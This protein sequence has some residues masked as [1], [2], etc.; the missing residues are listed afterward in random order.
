MILILQIIKP[1]TLRLSEEITSLFEPTQKHPVKYVK[2]VIFDKNAEE[3]F[4]FKTSKGFEA[5]SLA[6][7]GVDYLTV[8]RPT[9]SENLVYSGK[10]G[11]IP[12][13]T[14]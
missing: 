2:W 11:A 7:S 14:N 9:K 12:K 6:V 3:G 4:N 10:N 5:N 1:L 13:E 8:A